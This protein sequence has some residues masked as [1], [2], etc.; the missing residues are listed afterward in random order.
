MPI[1]YWR[2]F[3]GIFLY[4]S[5]SNRFLVFKFHI[6][7]L[8]F[9]Y[10]IYLIIPTGEDNGGNNIDFLLV[11]HI[12][13]I[14]CFIY[15]PTQSWLFY[16]TPPNRFLMSPPIETTVFTNYCSY[17][18]SASLLALQGHPTA[19]AVVASRQQIYK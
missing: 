18:L 13:S 17:N 7:L 10:Y 3:S 8:K 15:L 2:R 16:T 9:L 6:E 14:F 12:K 19:A 5:T 1:L 11:Q 4:F